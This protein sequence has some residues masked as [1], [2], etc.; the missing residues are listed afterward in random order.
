MSAH[1]SHAKQYVIIWVV[2]LAA[3]FASLGLGAVGSYPL[4]IAIIFAVATVKAWLVVGYFMG[5]ANEPYYLKAT[6]FTAVVAVAIFFGG[7]YKDVGAFWSGVQIVH[8]KEIVKDAAAE[9][10]PL[11]AGNPER[12]SK[13]YGTYC[14][15]CHQADGR[16][17]E[18][19]LAANFVDDKERM[20]QADDVLLG[21]IKNG[22]QGKIGAMPP[23]GATLKEQE[24]HDVLAYVRKTFTAGAQ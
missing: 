13:V 21:S 20:A 5:L 6:F 23:W 17:K 16:G 19:T 7:V 8:V 18:G 4:V 10:K 22:K 15:P 1:H 2:L 24:I 11:E 12:G 14:V 9:T 3:L